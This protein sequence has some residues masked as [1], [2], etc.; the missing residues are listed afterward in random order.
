MP[1]TGIVLMI[2]HRTMLW[3]VG[4]W[5]LTFPACAIIGYVVTIVV[6]WFTH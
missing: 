3:V 5:I 4:A 1:I 6:Q 2:K